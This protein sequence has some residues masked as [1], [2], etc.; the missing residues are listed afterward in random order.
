MSPDGHRLGRVGEP[1][2]VFAELDG[3]VVV[4]IGLAGEAD[5]VVEALL[6][7]GVGQL[8]DLAVMAPQ[9]HAARSDEKEDGDQGGSHGA[10]I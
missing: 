2:R 7:V 5:Q 8:L 4:A 3:A 9:G 1:E 10:R 6:G